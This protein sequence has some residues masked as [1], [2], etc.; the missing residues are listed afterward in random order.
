[1]PLEEYAPD[2]QRRLKALKNFNREHRA[3][4]MQFHNEVHE[5]EKKYLAL[6]TPLYEKRT[7]IV[8][9]KREPTEPESAYD[10]AD[11]YENEEERDMVH[12]MRK[13]LTLEQQKPA[14]KGA[15]GVPGFW[16]QTFQNYTRLSAE[17][18]DYDEP[19]LRHLVDVRQSYLEDGKHGFKLDF[20]FEANEYFSN[21]VLSKTYYLEP[22]KNAAEL[23]YDHAEGTKIEW[24]TG[25]D[26]T[27]ETIKKK[28]RHKSSGQVRITTKTEP[29]DSFFNFFSPP[30]PKPDEA[31]QDEEEEERLA[32]DYELG[33]ILKDRIIPRAV[34]Y[35][36]GEDHDSEDEDMYDEDYDEDMD[37]EDLDEDDDEDN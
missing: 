13:N 24:K 9:G 16:L 27:V 36:L 5:L 2:V 35:F 19:V 21:T 20:V 33:E 10:S 23:L 12:Q 22:E 34:A 1:M 32:R 17:I 29:R 30:E 8:S 6:Y 4:E 15:K 18:K 25:K 3:L 28:Q 11:E 31:E 7:E 37:D 26:V 14:D